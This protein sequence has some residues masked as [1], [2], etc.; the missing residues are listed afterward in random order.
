MTG[1]NPSDDSIAL[2]AVFRDEAIELLDSLETCLLDLEEN[3]N[4]SDLIDSGFRSLHT[5]KGIS[6]M[7]GYQAV[8]DL[9]HALE[10]PFAQARS[11][12][13]AVSASVL[14]IALQAADA[15]RDMVRADEPKDNAEAIEFAR[16]LEAQV[17]ASDGPAVPVALVDRRAPSKGWE[18][19][20]LSLHPSPEAFARGLRPHAI[21]AE[22]RA[23]GDSTLTACVDAV[24]ALDEIDPELCYLSWA[25]TLTTDK[26]LSA[27]REALMFL[28]ESEY[29]LDVLVEDSF[30]PE[31]RTGDE[32]RTAAVSV[33][34][35]ARIED[36]VR[37]ASRRLDG[38]VDL[39]GELVT[40]HGGMSN[41]SSSLG[42][43]R[44]MALTEEIGRLAA[45]LR[46]SVLQIRMV[47]VGSVFG[48]FR[49]HVHDLARDLGKKVEIETKGGET[50]LDKGVLDRVCEPILHI[51]RNSL[52]HGVELPDVR[53]AGG[54]SAVGTIRL[55]ARQAGGRVMITIIDDG[56]GIDLNAV[57]AR[58]T[59]LGLLPAG[60]QADDDAI[61]QTL[62][63]PGFSMSEQVTSVSGRGVGLDVVKRT[64]EE[65]HG[66]LSLRTELG[67]GT[68]LTLSLPLTLAIVEGLISRVGDEHFMIPLAAIEECSEFHRQPSWKAH[69]RN[70][71]ELHG[72]LLPAIDLREFFEIVGEEPEHRIVVIVSDDERRFA[73]AVD[74]LVD[75]VQ[76]VIKPLGRFMRRVDGVSGMT[77]LGDGSVV[78]I[79]DPGDILRVAGGGAAGTGEE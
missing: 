11:N 2:R 4:A 28:D 53:E 55:S 57:T 10:S 66:S 15:M 64:I 77:V 26:G 8:A 41:L 75:N 39:V 68:T 5:L 56:A 34:T 35:E 13:S 3:P 22:I 60:T 58:A 51:L 29:N 61:T 47:P 74:S 38:L 48:R 79:V 6:A 40:A 71:I 65:L 23:L 63:L 30:I 25:L 33:G 70:L 31:L 1:R 32:R 24:P 18:T 19:Y 36:S 16:R 62:F 12:G 69:E 37:V 14:E 73:L 54:K 78:P 43:A 72:Q 50:N 27:V 9:S 7:Y 20:R 59:G 17:H 44:L 42:D 21:L 49:R 52:D 67:R 45:D 46:E 76:A